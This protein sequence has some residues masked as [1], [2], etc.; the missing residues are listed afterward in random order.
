MAV[1]TAAEMALRLNVRDVGMEPEIEATIAEATAHIE[2]IVGPLE[3]STRTA[4]VSVSSGVAT[5]PVW[6]VLSVTSGVDSAGVTVDVSAVKVRPGGVLSSCPA[7]L[8]EVTYQAGR[9]S[10]PA[11][12]KA[13]L[14]ELTRHLWQA[15][16]S[17]KAGPGTQGDGQAP[18][19]LIPN[20]VAALLEPH[21]L[22]GFA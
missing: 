18:G 22:P 14:V 4:L 11:D 7:S 19:Y 20:R 1:L 16:R 12:L 8:Y 17:S 6:P 10:C 15:R 2:Q 21:R 3:P 13:A 9:A 5:V